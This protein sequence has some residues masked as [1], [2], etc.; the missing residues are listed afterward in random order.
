MQTLEYL[1]SEQDVRFFRENGYWLGPR[2][3]DE[4]RLER[5]RAAMDRVY[6]GE[7]ETGRAPWAGGWKP[8]GNPLEVRK[9]DNAHWANREI[10]ALAL[11]PAIGA[12]AARL[13]GAP[14]IRL[15]HDQL[16][17]KPGQA[18]GAREGGNVGWHQDSHYWQC[19]PLEL[20][21]AWV[22][23]DDV[24][25]ENGCMSVVPGSHQWGLLPAGD[26]FS[27]DMAAMGA[28][29]ERLTGRPFQTVPCPLPA[30]AVSFHHCLTIHGSGP[31]TTARP[32]RSLAIHLMPGSDRYIAGTSC[33]NHMN[34]ILMRERGGRDGDFFHGD[35]W[36]ALYPPADRDQE[37]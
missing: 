30:G 3:L 16:L 34:A 4:A 6:A 9:T 28:Q 15:W 21:T 14:S 1:P 27:Q 29:Y 5:L 23:F 26:F 24:T 10:R 2:I 12:I 35:L 18:G 22:A 37:L 25:P 17:Y 20:I 33:D 31:N 13:L 8:S 19:A 7:F 32:R 11:D 36:P